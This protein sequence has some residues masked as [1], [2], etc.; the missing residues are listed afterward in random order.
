MA[1]NIL[2]PAAQADYESRIIAAHQSMTDEYDSN[3]PRTRVGLCITHG[4]GSIAWIKVSH[5]EDDVRIHC[6]KALKRHA[7]ADVKK[8]AAIEHLERANRN[9]KTS[10]STIKAVIVSWNK[11]YLLQAAKENDGGLSVAGDESDGSDCESA[12]STLDKGIPP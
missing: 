6:D 12:T 3:F 4:P 5:D 10:I 7:W 1:N 8:D 9:T 11:H 2:N